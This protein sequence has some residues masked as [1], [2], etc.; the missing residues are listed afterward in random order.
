MEGV[1]IIWFPLFFPI[2]QLELTVTKEFLH[3]STILGKP[4]F[5]TDQYSKFPFVL[6]IK[7]VTTLNIIKKIPESFIW[8]VYYHR[9]GLY[10]VLL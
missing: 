10:L 2:K 5:C 7:T 8:E 4:T 3:K 9:L 1:A 6:A